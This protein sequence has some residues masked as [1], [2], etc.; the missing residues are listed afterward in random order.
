VRCPCRRAVRDRGRSV[1]TGRRRP[2]NRSSG[3]TAT[4]LLERGDEPVPNRTR[5]PSGRHAPLRPR[6]PARPRNPKT[7]DLLWQAH[8]QGPVALRDCAPRPP[9]RP[10]PPDGLPPPGGSSASTRFPHRLTSPV[11]SPRTAARLDRDWRSRVAGSVDENSPINPFEDGGWRRLE[12]AG[13]PTCLAVGVDHRCWGL[14][15]GEGGS[16]VGW[17]VGRATRGREEDRDSIH[18]AHSGSGSGT[19][20]P[21]SLVSFDWGL[22][23]RVQVTRTGRLLSGVP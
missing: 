20:G 5:N 9:D 4:P 23:N 13:R 15:G 14:P 3:T 12:E 7:P 16:S 2:P 11:E 19:A 22:K 18:V 10:P 6:H 21:A 8:H 1:T 17:E